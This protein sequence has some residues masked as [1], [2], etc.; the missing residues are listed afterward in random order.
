MS[1]RSGRSTATANGDRASIIIVG[2]G[3]LGAGL[4]QRLAKRGWSVTLVDQ[5]P[6]GHARAASAS[7]SRIIRYS[8]GSSVADT[9]SAWEARSLWREIEEDTGAELMLHPGMA[10]FASDDDSWEADSQLVLEQERIPF[11]RLDAQDAAGLFPDLSVNDL[12]YVL[13]E[14]DACALHAR[15][16]VRALCE[17]AL[18]C[19]ARFVGGRARPVE[20]GIEI[21]GRLM[22]ADRIVWACGAW[23]VKLFP[24]LVHG[25]V[26]Q[27][28]LYYVGVP[29]GW[30]C[31]AVPA[32]GQYG[33][34]VTGLGDLLGRGFKLGADCPGPEF[35][36]DTGQRIPDLRQEAQARAYLAKRF[37]AIADAPLV[38]TETCQTTVLSTPIGDE[39]LTHAGQRMMR[40]PD[41]P[42][43]WILGDGSGSVFKH[44]PAIARHMQEI[45]TRESRSV[46]MH[47]APPA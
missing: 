45:L 2:L 18:V 23:T 33:E 26:I 8:H 20:G 5:Y 40:H 24:E 37:P 43:M 3:V 7:N 30:Q 38:G 39:I 14:P 41:H 16:A 44:G 42:N 34:R 46:S 4:G 29:L 1:Q 11:E 27:Q 35:D 15:R 17:H 25:A 9:R 21:E 19:G 31:P 47:T 10:W 22:T 28:D 13:F 32:W 12:K 36:P 6:F